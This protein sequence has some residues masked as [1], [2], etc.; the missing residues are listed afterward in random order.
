MKTSFYL[1]FLVLV[2]FLAAC[3]PSIQTSTEPAENFRLSDY[4]TFDFFKVDASG[5]GLG[6]GYRTQ[7]SYIQDEI[8]R[9]LEQRGLRRSS[10]DPDLLVNLGI[11]VRDTVQTRE[12]DIRTDPPRYVG[13]RRYT[14]KTREVVVR[15]YKEGSISVHLVDNDRNELVWRGTAEGVLEERTPK[16]QEQ[17]SEG[18]QEL[19]SQIQQ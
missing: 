5:G 13:Q 10:T 15:R 9:Q 14:W 1:F 2:I 12:T 4:Q 11:V 19:F 8:A 7:V 18:M 6:P 16:I 17:I 3:S